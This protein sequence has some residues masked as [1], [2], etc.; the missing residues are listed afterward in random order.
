M[1]ADE[2]FRNV[3]LHTQAGKGAVAGFS[4]RQTTIK[5]PFYVQNEWLADG[6]PLFTQPAKLW[7]PMHG[8]CPANLSLSDQCDCIE[9]QLKLVAANNTRRPLFI[10]TY[11]VQTFVDVALAMQERLPSDEWAV[12]GAQDFAVLGRAAAPSTRSVTRATPLKIDE[13][14]ARC[15]CSNMSL[16]RPLDRAPTA[17]REVHSYSDCGGPPEGTDHK[18]CDWRSFNFSVLS[19]VV[20]GV[21][22]ARLTIDNDGAVSTWPDGDWP[23]SEFLCYAHSRNVRVLAVAL[24]APHGFD[25]Y[26]LLSNA[27]AISRAASGLAAAMVAGGFD[28]LEFD[29][30]SLFDGSNSTFDYGPAHVSLVAQTREAVRRAYQH[31]T[32]SLTV[33]SVANSRGN[34]AYL[35]AYPLVQLSEAADSLFVM[36][37]DMWHAH[38]IC[39]GPN[40][41]LQTIKADLTEYI[42]SGVAADKLVLGIPAYGH[43]YFCNGTLPCTFHACANSTCICGSLQHE[44]PHGPGPGFWAIDGQLRNRSNRFFGDGGRCTRGYSEDAQSPFI[45]CP[46]RPG[47]PR[48]Q[49]WY[50]DVEST[51]LKVALAKTL[52]LGGGGVFT[53]ED[54]AGT[55]ASGTGSEMWAALAAFKSDRDTDVQAQ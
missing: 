23:D 5:S 34:R 47:V 8:P 25:Y 1:L 54:L 53:A 46:A 20:R 28:G 4:Q 18:G 39:A 55:G 3:S 15:S 42:H 19:T 41:P 52:G 43:S 6:T 32:V 40:A 21:H 51:R 11:G 13:G 50:D 45:N 17:G 38:G 27:T 33:G 12:V 26:R 22:G 30:E 48:T 16:C 7:Y 29:L 35:A 31:A 14:L 2:R 44:A 49:T 10:P 36:A 24:H 9:Q 37:Y